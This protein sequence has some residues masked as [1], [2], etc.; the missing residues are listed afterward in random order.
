MSACESV[1][2]ILK[3]QE[4]SKAEKA[5]F[6]EKEMS[7][8]TD[9]IDCVNDNEYSKEYISVIKIAP[10]GTPC[11]WILI[12]EDYRRRL[13]IEKI[14]DN[15]YTIKSLSMYSDYTWIHN[16]NIESGVFA[17]IFK[18]WPYI[19]SQEDVIKLIQGRVI[20]NFKAQAPSIQG[21]RA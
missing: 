1:K 2:E 15:Q 8:I 11:I 19:F 17:K 3:K 12:R 14:G 20:E 6:I 13:R 18:K 9:F 5:A 10:V 16:P 21:K 4:E 7:F